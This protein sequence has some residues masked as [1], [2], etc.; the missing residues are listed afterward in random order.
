[1]LLQ[2]SHKQANM[3]AVSTKRGKSTTEEVK[4]LCIS[5][6]FPFSSLFFS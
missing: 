2:A 3:W 1:M 6:P 4:E 5:F